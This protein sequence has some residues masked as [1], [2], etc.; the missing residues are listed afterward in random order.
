[1]FGDRLWRVERNEAVTSGGHVVR[2]QNDA[3]VSTLPGPAR[4][5]LDQFADIFE[6]YISTLDPYPTGQAGDG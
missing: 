4:D 6:R 3:P 1:V 2:V 5:R